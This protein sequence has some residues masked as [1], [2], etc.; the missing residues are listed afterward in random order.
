MGRDHTGFYGKVNPALSPEL[1]Q[2]QTTG[3]VSG[4]SFRP[5]DPGEQNGAITASAD[6]VKASFQP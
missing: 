2:N 5:H 4:A 6:H 1:R 3:W